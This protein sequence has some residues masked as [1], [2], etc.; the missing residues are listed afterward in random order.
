M[1][2][3][4]IFQLI[5]ER[6]EELFELLSSFIKI[7]SENFSS[8]GNEEALARY[9]HK[10][11]EELGLESEL[12]SPLE[13]EGFEEHPDYFP[14]R[15]LENRYNVTA[16]WR[17]VEDVDDLM[18]MGHTDTVPIGD[19]S[20][21]DRDPLSGAVEDGKIHGRGVGDDKYALATALFLIKL[22]KEEG[23]V[24]KKN[25]VFSAY[26]DEEYGGS[27]GALASVLR[28]PCNRIVS[29]DCV[30]DQIWHCGSGGQVVHYSFHTKEAVDSA[31]KGADA[32]PVVMEE[33]E[34]F[35]ARRRAELGENPYYKGTII[36][37]TA[38]RYMEVRVGNKGNDMGKG[39]ISFTYYT[40]KTREEIAK[41]FRALEET[42]AKRL[43]SM[44]IVG[45]G[46]TPET[47]FF[48]YVH[49]EPDSADIKEM[50][51][52]SREATGKEPLVCGSCLSDLS[53]IS[54]YGSSQAYGFGLGRDF[55]LP[56]G[57]HQPNEYILCDK[58]VDYTK[59]IAAYILRTLG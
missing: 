48:H 11:C 54:K 17:G 22:L 25:I 50:L 53:V 57:A 20:A 44:G 39:E 52:A 38:M 10:M 34:K 28:Y 5:E 33:L 18:L 14:G 2:T 42:L 43:D 40:D 30:E 12:Y 19:P 26:S 23:F 7:N 31:K 36:P 15:G 45:D 29:M 32:I 13:L 55:S 3:K 1:E 46:I 6:R 56:G 49:C 37:E 21:W 35:G 9:I 51:A 4:R 27:H 47:R 16:R 41:E 8:Y 59:T 58:L 24:P